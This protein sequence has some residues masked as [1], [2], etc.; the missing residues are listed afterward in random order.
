MT[1]SQARHS[2]D[3]VNDDH[4]EH[5]QPSADNHDYP[6]SPLSFMNDYFMHHDSEVP[7]SEYFPPDASPEDLV[8]SSEPRG[9]QDSTETVVEEQNETRAPKYP[10][11]AYQ[12]STD[13]TRRYM[14][15]STIVLRLS[16]L[17]L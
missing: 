14:Y 11:D 10:D 8:A 4:T 3:E 12:S 9:S 15:T 2:E 17:D 5:S 16:H 13:S 1:S 7:A 6:P